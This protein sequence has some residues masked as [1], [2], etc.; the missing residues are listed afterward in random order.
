VSAAADLVRAEGLSTHF[1][2]RQGLGDRLRRRDGALVRAVDRVDLRVGPGEIVGL[3]GESGC[4]KTTL[5][6]TIMGLLPAAEGTLAFNGVDITHAGRG[7]W[8]GLRRRMQMIFQDPYASLS[9][10]MRVSAL[11]EEPYRIHDVPADERYAVPEL[12]AMVGLSAEQAEKYPHELSG[13]QA[14]RIGIARTLALR[15]E[16]I[17]ADEP[18]SGL[19]V[20]AAAAI[21]NLIQ[22]LRR[23]HGLAFLVITHNV[24]TLSFLAD[25][26]A[27]MYLGRVVE[28]G[29]TAD[30]LE[31]PSHP[32][33]RAL[34]AAVPDI[35]PDGVDVERAA[36]IE[37]EIPS[38][39]DPPSGC[40]FRTRCP[41]ARPGV[42]EEPPVLVEIEPGHA[43]A[44]GR[45]PDVQRDEAWAQAGV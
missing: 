10:R 4:G 22:D 31:R 15:P 41:H 9:P 36:L 18:T 21:L 11:L 5:G 14:R 29:T 33:T 13:G 43:I 40:R 35:E 2:M 32:Y 16:F 1:A 23:Q 27:V 34:L 37:G 42:C 8:R 12:L 19:D 30:V 26:V 20:S 17:V 39:L 45:W 6:R 28:S 24:N 3:V 7:E 38:P 44:C 25:R